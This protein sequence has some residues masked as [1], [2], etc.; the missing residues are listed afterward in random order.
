MGVI[1]SVKTELS[2]AAHCS[3]CHGNVTASA[4]NASVQFQTTA[5]VSCIDQIRINPMLQ[6]CYQVV[7]WLVEVLNRED[8]LS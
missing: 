5:C 8:H 1:L 7:K 4:P 6:D 3:D 2:P